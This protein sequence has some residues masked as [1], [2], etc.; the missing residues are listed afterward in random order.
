MHRRACEWALGCLALLLPDSALYAAEPSPSSTA[1]SD[2]L[3][4]E[5]LTG[6]WGG[7]RSAWEKRGVELD[8]ALTQFYQGVA[9]GGVRHDSEYNGTFVTDAR[10]DLGKLAGWKFWQV[11]FQTQTRFGGPVLG[12]TGTISPANTAAIIPGTDDTV[13]AI[14]ALSVT[15]L[16]PIDLERGDVLAIAA[17]RVNLIDAV[18]EQFFAG[19]GTERFMNIAQIGPLTVAR[20]VP[21]ITNVL[22]FAYVRHGEPFITFSILDP[23]DHSTNAGLSDL[24][25]DGVTFSPG[26][27]FPTRYFGKSGTHSFGGAITTKDY[28]PFD[29]LRQLVLPGPPRVPQEPESGSWSVNYVFR[30]YLVERGKDDGWGVFAQ[31][32]FANESTSPITEFI[33]IGVGG[34]GLLQRRPDD[35]FGIA[36]AYTDLSDDLKDDLDLLRVPGVRAEHQVEMFY[37]AHITPWF[38]L[39]GDLQ[40]IRPTREGVDTAVIPAIRLKVIF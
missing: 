37:N 11:D 19:G 6:D 38:R 36:Y 2:P 14:T 40:V 13:F 27:N 23:N 34:N 12:G 35:E 39:T 3:H 32:A 18:Q 26:I 7:A 17:G 5:Q 33:N 30:Q 4:R 16:I 28:T 22:S 1:P 25:E 10:L 20:E 8:F 9:D 24:F 29:E 15:R 31:L 21:L